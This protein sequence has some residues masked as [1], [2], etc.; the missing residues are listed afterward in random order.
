MLKATAL[1]ASLLTGLIILFAGAFVVPSVSLA[2]LNRG[3]VA[4][5]NFDE[6]SGT[7]LHDQA[8]SN[9]GTINGATWKPTGGISGGALSF[10]GDNDYVQFTNPVRNT[11]P[12]TVA[13]WVK[14]AGLNAIRYAISNGGQTDNSYGF[15]FDEELSKGT[16]WQWGV[17]NQSGYGNYARQSGA[18]TDWTFLCGVWDGTLTAN[19]VKLYVNGVLAGQST[20]GACEVG[21]ADDLRIGAPSNALDWMWLGLIDEVRIYDIALSA[22]E[23]D[24][25]YDLYYV[26][27][28]PPTV[29]I[30]NPPDYRLYIHEQN[31]ILIVGTASDPDGTI[32]EVQ[33]KIDNGSWTHATGIATWIYSWDITGVIDGKHI[34]YA[35]SKDNQ[36]A[37]SDMD[38]VITWVNKI[39]FEPPFSRPEISWRSSVGCNVRDNGSFVDANGDIYLYPEVWST[40]LNFLG[41]GGWVTGLPEGFGGSETVNPGDGFYVTRSGNYRVTFNLNSQ[42][43]YDY[44]KWS[45]GFPWGACQVGG[46]VETRGA[47]AA[48]P[49]GGIVNNVGGNRYEYRSFGSDLHSLILEVILS[50]VPFWAIVELIV[51]GD[52]PSEEG[53]FPWYKDDDLDFVVSLEPGVSYYPAFASAPVQCGIVGYGAAGGRIKVQSQVHVNSITVEFLSRL[54]QR[55]SESKQ[56][57]LTLSVF[58]KPSFSHILTVD[59]EGDGDFTTIRDAVDNADLGDTIEVYSGTYIENLIL[60]KPITLKGMPYELGTGSDTGSPVLDASGLALENVGSAGISIGVDSC[61]VNGFVI[62]NSPFAGVSLDSASF[63]NFSNNRF[64][65]N[66]FG[67]LFSDASDYNMFSS[68]VFEH[69]VYAVTINNSND[70]TFSDN[71]FNENG[72]GFFVMASSDNL[73]SINTFR[74]NGEGIILGNS[75]NNE[76][77]GNS[78]D[79]C[80]VQ[81][82]HISG[83]VDNIISGNSFSRCGIS[84][85]AAESGIGTHALVNNTVDGKPIYYYA[86]MDGVSVPTDAGQVILQNCTNFTIQNLVITAVDY[87][88]QLISSSGNSISQCNISECFNG[89]VLSE[90]DSNTISGNILSGNSTFGIV[91]AKSRNNQLLGNTCINDGITLFGDSLSFWNTHTMSDNTVND[92]AILYYADADSVAVPSNAGQVIL[93]NCTHF[94]IDSLNVSNVEYAIQL[95]YSSNNLVSGC[96]F[97]DNLVGLILESSDSNNITSCDFDSNSK[98]GVF[99]PSGTENTFWNN[100]FTGNTANA[101]EDSNGRGN[102]W[103]L[104]ALGNRW[105]DFEEN[106]GYPSVYYIPGPGDGVDYHPFGA[107]VRGDANGDGVI[108]SAD[109]SYLINYLFVSGPAPFPLVAGDANCDGNV[110][111]ADVAY[112][113]NYLFVSGPAPGC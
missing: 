57:S 12:Y 4:Y 113:I 63:N 77:T 75:T 42:G 6:G 9:D 83:G 74:W 51:K 94:V 84:F 48:N 52:T 73:L 25:L 49:V 28:Q 43:F 18:T 81:G 79:T 33:V 23:I 1:R 39:V 99:I 78:F 16:V 104:G 96:D 100:T 98:Y 20:A 80:F 65:N 69:Q 56:R 71:D 45:Y 41:L 40:L 112:L 10:D 27:N 30:N 111:S 47:I 24:S 109:V 14:T 87:G 88:I 37:W 2:D 89:I 13:I 101:Y 92:K 35:K 31:S 38:S 108:N 19:A 21:S 90:S 29:E 60:D 55:N 15:Y 70:N 68:N 59:N 50:G 54:S 61:T 76:L 102:L 95:G 93:A 8:G 36:G 82:I 22:A 32:E 97:S 107:F 85:S 62:S 67:I 53:H 64:Q 106:P 110:N 26:P 11:P 72:A 34:I 7:V 17:R 103:N 66:K 105:G 44:N 91:I 86:N 3:L 5:W 46:S 58:E